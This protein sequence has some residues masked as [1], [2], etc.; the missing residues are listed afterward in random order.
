[1]TQLL[2]LEA[3]FIAEGKHKHARNVKAVIDR[4]NETAKVT[5]LI[6]GT[7]IVIT[8]LF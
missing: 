8:H 2:E 3:R 4:V 6:P 7:Y 5:P 1:M